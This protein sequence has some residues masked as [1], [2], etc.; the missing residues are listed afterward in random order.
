[1]RAWE[2]QRSQQVDPLLLSLLLLFAACLQLLL[3]S[4]P[5]EGAHS[6]VKVPNM[7]ITVTFFV[8]FVLGWTCS[9]LSK[10][11]A[12]WRRYKDHCYYFS[13]DYQRWREALNICYS[14]G[15]LLTS[16]WDRN[17]QNWLLSQVNR[18]A[19]NWIGLF[20]P[21]NHHAEKWHWWQWV[22]GTFYFKAVSQWASGYPDSRERNGYCAAMQQSGWD[23][24]DCNWYLAYICKRPVDET[25]CP[26]CPQCPDCRCNFQPVPCPN[27][28]CPPLTCPTSPAPS[29]LRMSTTAPPTNREPEICTS[30]ASGIACSSRNVTCS[31]LLPMLANS[32]GG[33]RAALDDGLSVNRRIVIRG[34]ANPQAEKLVV[35]LL[36]RDHDDNHDGEDDD[37]TALHLRVNFESRTI[38]L[39]SRVDDSWGEK[40]QEN[41][42]EQRP[43]G[44]GL[45][46][47]IVIW[48][49]ADA[50]RLTFNDIHQ[51]HY[52]YQVEDLQSIK[53][54]EV[55]SALLTGI[56]LM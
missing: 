18:D 55:W 27:F 17:E 46:F 49:D 16:I 35:N 34:R 53:W 33:L 48:Y 3:R 32:Q 39:N 14:K 37:A 56:Q 43:F 29:Y 40:R 47:K 30:S 38:V 51:M 21:W 13:N 36:V 6:R 20:R 41:F 28:T 26:A 22:D 45:D 4:F 7:R 54:L 5:S 50:F 19:V 31:C 24:K 42:P 8:N 2:Q 44:P 12:D 25:P 10:C 9:A 23:N 52:K 1:M 11:P 15:G